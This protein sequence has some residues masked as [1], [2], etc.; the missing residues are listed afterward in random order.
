MS[1]IVLNECAPRQVNQPTNRMQHIIAEILEE[2]DCQAAFVFCFFLLRPFFIRYKTLD[3]ALQIL[4]STF[5]TSYYAH[6]A[7]I[8]LPCVASVSIDVLC[9][10]RFLTARI[11]QSLRVQTAKIAQNIT[12]TLATQGII[13][14]DR[15]TWYQ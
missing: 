2:S 7:V 12:E 15:Q 8:L 14:Q 5:R 11:L 13:S 4:F 3:K 10:F 9:V 6:R 1:L